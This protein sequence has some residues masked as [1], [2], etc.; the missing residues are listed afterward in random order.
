[1]RG[2]R[3]GG[4]AAGEGSRGRAIARRVAGECAADGGRR[5]RLNVNLLHAVGSYSYH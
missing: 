1:L 2:A 5:A 3:R 4:G